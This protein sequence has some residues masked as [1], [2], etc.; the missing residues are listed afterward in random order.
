[1][2]LALADHL[3]IPF[4]EVGRVLLRRSARVTGDRRLDQSQ[5]SVPSAY[6]DISIRSRRHTAESGKRHLEA[7]LND[8]VVASQI[9]GVAVH[10]LEWLDVRKHREAET[11]MSSDSVLGEDGDVYTPYYEQVEPNSEDGKGDVAAGGGASL[12][13]VILIGSFAGVIFVAGG[14][15]LTV[16]RIRRR[17]AMYEVDGFPKGAMEDIASHTSEKCKEKC[18]VS[19]HYDGDFSEAVF[20]TRVVT[21][22][23]P[24]LMDDGHSTTPS[25]AADMIADETDCAPD[26]RLDIDVHTSSAFSSGLSPARSPRGATSKDEKSMISF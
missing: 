10:S 19:E 4:Q 26:C 11:N 18:E 13:P 3:D 16:R 15:F 17:N 25:E 14:V 24:D 9:L 21:E 1:M 20:T 23:P 12:L 8:A 2:R 6:L 5:S 22:E 7:F